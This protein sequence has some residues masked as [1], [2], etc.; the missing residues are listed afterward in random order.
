MATFRYAVSA[1]IWHGDPSV[2]GYE[3]I[4]KASDMGYNG[5]EI[6]TFDGNIDENTVNQKL[7]SAS[8]KMEAIIVGGG[9]SGMDVSSDDP[10]IRENGLNYMKTLI[11]RASRIDSN[12]VCGPL[13]S[14]V[15]K[16]LY[17]SDAER[18]K[19][20]RRT[21]EVIKEA[22]KYAEDRGIDM[23]LEPLCRYDSYLINTTDQMLT[24]LDMVDAPNLGVLL[25]TFHMNIEEDS[26]VE[27]IIKSAHQFRHFQVCDNNRG[28][29]GK[30]H[31]EWD[32][33]ANAVRK[34]GYKG[35]ISL[36][37]FTPYERVFSEMMRSWR[38][39]VK[40][41][42]IFAKEAL[43]YLKKIFNRY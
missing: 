8:S 43:G 23:A 5:V 34:S 27:P 28:I 32:S 35:W 25:D 18:E 31:I 6:P 4:E 3:F 39:L 22:A 20:L 36:E 30:G 26:M 29:P 19:V 37:S 38:P 14:A 42:D 12:L 10:M 21:A 9:S 33:I 1:W 24:F 16:A 15:G 11:N 7:G 40:N 13:F 17:L 41:Q 2:N